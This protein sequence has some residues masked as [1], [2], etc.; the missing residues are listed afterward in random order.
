MSIAID[1]V[2]L[3]VR[4]L[5][6]RYRAKGFFTDAYVMTIDREVSLA[7]FVE[8]FYTTRLFKLERAILAV[9]VRKP[10]TDAQARALGLGEIDA[11]AAWTVEARETEQLLLRD[12]NGGTR[13]WLMRETVDGGTRLYFGSVV[14]GKS[15][16][17][18]GPPRMGLVFRALLGF[19]RRYSV[20]L[21]R[22]AHRRLTRR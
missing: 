5:T 12:L 16:G 20:G 2:D 10:S 11:F 7:A 21:M 6:Q 8:A 1:A 18:A 14:V 3:P 9:I 17:A 15:D 4:A 19:H 13:S 22:A